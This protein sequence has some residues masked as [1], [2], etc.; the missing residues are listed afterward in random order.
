MSDEMS[1]GVDVDPVV[2][3][4][5]DLKSERLQEDG[6]MPDWLPGSEDPDLKS[7]RLQD[8]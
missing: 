6:V 8:E 5:P 1:V 3:I 2:E 7:E 4:E